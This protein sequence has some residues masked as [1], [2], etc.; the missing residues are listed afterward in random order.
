MRAAASADTGAR[1][2]AGALR[3]RS[4]GR[5]AGC[6][7]LGLI[8]RPS[9]GGLQLQAITNALALGAGLPADRYLLSAVQEEMSLRVHE[10]W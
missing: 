4:T 1:P 8:T 10:D 7:R 6:A 3:S 2:V 5:A 9:H